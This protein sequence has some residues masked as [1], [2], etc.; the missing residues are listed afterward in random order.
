MRMPLMMSLISPDKRESKS[1]GSGE[2]E[3]AEQ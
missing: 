2:R 3:I 1:F